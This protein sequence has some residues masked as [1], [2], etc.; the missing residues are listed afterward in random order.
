VLFSDTDGI[1]AV[2]PTRITLQAP[3]I[4]FIGPTHTTGDVTGD[5]TA[6]Y[7]KEVTANGGHTVSQHTHTQPADSHGDTE[8]PT[9]TPT[10]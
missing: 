7:A 2:S 5:Q 8:Q 9:N 1:K 4:Q 10:G 6:T 3:D